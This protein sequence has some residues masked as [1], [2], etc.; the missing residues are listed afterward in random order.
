MAET[1]QVVIL[2]LT[3][4]LTDTYVDEFKLEDRDPEFLYKYDHQGLLK[5]RT[6]S[7]LRLQ[8]GLKVT[9]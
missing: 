2:G 6:K 4:T 8:M 5:L 1:D 9:L 3:K 7:K